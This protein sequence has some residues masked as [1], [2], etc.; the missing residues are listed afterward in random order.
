MHGAF[1]PYQIGAF[2]PLPEISRYRTP[3]D[4][5][6]LCGAG[7]HPGAGVT[8]GPGRNAAIAICQDKGIAFPGMVYGK[9]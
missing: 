5:V 3:V 2:R 1:L 7:A 8:M 6:Y 4:G 9:G